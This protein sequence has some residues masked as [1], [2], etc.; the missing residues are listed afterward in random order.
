MAGV[1]ALAAQANGACQFLE[2]L[3]G[4]VPVDACVSDGLAVNQQGGV[5]TRLLI[6]LDQ[7]GLEHYGGDGE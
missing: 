4:G 2:H 5:W 3:D 7:V 6:A 1:L